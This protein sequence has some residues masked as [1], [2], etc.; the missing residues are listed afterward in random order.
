MCPG[1]K[2]DD[3]LFTIVI[4]KSVKKYKMPFYLVRLLKGKVCSFK[5][6]VSLSGKKITFS[7]PE[8]R[9]NVDGEIIPMDKAE[10]ELI[11]DAIRIY[12]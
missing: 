10:I 7:C 6:T 9:V 3:G 12:R 5:E 1:A 11:P 4:V 2:I 8:M